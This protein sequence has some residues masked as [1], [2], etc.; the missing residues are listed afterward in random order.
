[1]LDWK[2]IKKDQPQEKPKSAPVYL[3]PV[4]VG[5]QHQ[6]QNNYLFS[7]NSIGWSNKGKSNGNIGVKIFL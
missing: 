4:D 6:D 3:Q 7:N 5:L 2:D 1:M